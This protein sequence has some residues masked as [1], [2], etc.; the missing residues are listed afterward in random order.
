M[1]AEE[2]NPMASI[3]S[4][5]S[6]SFKQVPLAALPAMLDCILASTGISPSTLF[7]SLLNSFSKFIKCACACILSLV[8]LWG[9][10]VAA[11]AVNVKL[12][13]VKSMV[14][15]FEREMLNEIAESLFCVISTTHSWGVLEANLVPFFL[16]SVGL[17]MGMFQNEE[18]DAFEWGHCSI[19][20]GLSDLENDFD[21]DKESMLS[22]SGSFPLP[23]SCHI[24]TLIL[25]SALQ[26]F[27]IVSSTKSTLANGFCYAEKLFSNLLWDL[28]NMSERLLSQ[29]LEHRSCTIGFLLPVIFKAFGSHCSL[30]ITVR[31]KMFILSRN[32]F[33]RKIWKLCRSLFSL[34]HLERRDAYNVLSLYLSFFSST[35]GFGNA[36]ANVKAEEFD[37]RAEK[38]FWDE[39]KRGLV[40]G[41][42]PVRKQSLHILK[43]ILQISGGSQCHSGVSEKKSPEKHPIPHGMTKREMWADKEAKSLG[44]WELCNLAD[45]PLNSQQQWE[46][47]IILYEMLEEYGTHLV[48]AAWHHQLNLLLQF[49]VSNNNFTSY[50]FKGFHQKQTDILSEAFSWVTI[51]WQLGFQHDNPQVRCLIMESFLGIE[52]MKYGNTAKLVSESFVLGPFIEG[53]NDPVHHKDFG[54][55]GVYNSKTIEGAARWSVLAL[56][57]GIAFL[58][59]LASVAKHFS[60]GRAGLM[61]L[62]ECIA[63]AAHG[64]GR[65]GNEEKWTEDAFPDEVLVKSSSEN[66]S[67][68]QTSILDVLRFVIKS[69][70]QHFNPNY[71]LKVCEKV[72]E[73][74]A[75]LVSTLDVPLEILLHFIATLPRAFTDYGDDED[76]DAWESEAKRW[77]RALFLIIK[78]EHQLA[79]ILRFFQN[80]GVNICKQQN[81]LEWLPVKFLVLARSLVAEIQIMQERFTQC[82]IK[83]KCRSQIS[84]LDTEELVSFADMSSS[85]FWSSI[86]EETTLPGSVRGKLGGRSQRRLSTSNTTV[87]LQAIISMQ[88]VASISSWCAQFKS[89]V[90]LRSVWAF[91]WKFFWK[92]VSSPTCDSEVGAE[93]CLAAYEAL[94]P[95]LRALVSTSS[96]LSLDLIR[97]N[98]E[99]SAPAEEVK[100]CLDSLALS[101][102]QNINNLLAVGVLARTRRAVLLNQKWI[103]LESLLS[104]PYSTPGNVLNVEDGS[105]FFSDSTIRCIFSDL[106]ESLDNAGEGS[107]L[108]ML[109]SVRL[110]LGL[111]ALGKLDSPISSCNGVDAQ[112]C[113]LD[114]FC[115]VRLQM[116]VT[117][118]SRQRDAL[119]TLPWCYTTD[120]SSF[121]G[122]GIR[123]VKASNLKF[124]ENVIEEGTKSPRTIRLTALHLTGLWLSHPRTIKY[125]MKELKLLT[126]YGSEKYFQYDNF[127]ALVAFDEDFEAELSENQDASNEVSLL[128]KS[129]DPELTELADLANMVG[130]KKENEDCQAALESGKLFLL[131]LL[132]SAI[133]SLMGLDIL[134]LF[135]SL[136]TIC[137]VNDKDLA[138]ELYKKYSGI[139]YS[140]PEKLGIA[141]S[142]KIHRRKIRAWQMICVLSRF[143]TDD[144]A[145]QVTH[146]L[147]ISLHRNNLPAVRQYLETFAI[148]IYLKFPLLVRGQ[149]VPILRDYNMK[150]QALS[151]YVFIAAN[152]ILHASNANQSRHFNELL[153]PIIP[154]LTSHHHSLRGFTQLLVYQVFCKYFPLLDHGASEMPLEKMCFEDLK[155]YL[156]KNPDCRRLRASMEGYLD[157]YNP[158]A[159]GT[160]AGIFVNRV[161]NALHQELEF[162]CVATSL[163]EEVLNFLNDVREDLRCSMAKD[164]VTIKNESLK[165]D[166]DGNCRQTLIDSQ[167]PTE[168]SFDFQKKLTLSKHEKQDTDSSSVLGNNEAYKQLLEMEKE[169]ELLD[170]SF[171]SRSLTMKKIRASRQQFILVASLLDRIPN[172]AGLARTCE[173]FKASGLA[174]ADASILRDKQ[175]QLIS[176]T[177]EKWVP[178]IEVPVNSVKHFLEKKKRD[179][180]SI[181]GLEQTTNSVPLDHYAFP[182]KTVL[183]LGHEKE[184]IPVDIIHMLDACIEIPQLGVV[185]SLNVHALRAPAIQVTVRSGKSNS[186]LQWIEEASLAY[187]ERLR[188]SHDVFLESLLQK[189]TY[190]KLYSYTHLLNGFAVNVQSKEVLR[191]LK[192]ATGVRAIHEDV[193]M[194]KFTTH[195]PR[196]LGIPTDVWPTLGGA[197]NSG[198]GV[199]IGFIDTGINPLHPSFTGG[200]TARFTNSSKFKGKCVTGEKFPSTACNGKIVGAQYFARAAIAAGD[201][202]ATRD[203]ASPYDADG[204]GR[205][206]IPR[207]VA[208]FLHDSFC[209]LPSLR[210]LHTASTAAGNH[211]I[212][213]IAND[214]NYGYASGMAPG[215]RCRGCCGSAIINNL[216]QAVEDGVDILNLSIGPSSVPS[217]PSAFLNVLEMELLFATKAG[218]FVV[219]AAGNGGPSPSSILSFSPW[220]TSVAASIIDRKYNN[221][222]ILGN[223]R[224]FS[225]TGLARNVP[226]LA[227]APTEGEMPYRI[228]AAADVSHTNTTSVV[229][230]E[231]CQNP[232]HFILSSVR[233]KLIICTYTFD[234]EYEAASIAA[235][236]ST[237]QKIG[238]AGFIIAMDPDIGSEQIKGATMTI[239]VPAIILNSLQSS[240]ALWEY[241]NSNTIRSTSGQAV[242]FAARARILDGRQAF[243]TRQAPI[244][245]SYSS[246]GPDVSNALL[247]TADVLK[248]NIMAPGSSIWAAWSPNSEGDPSIKGQNFALVS[249]TSMATPHIAGVAALIKQKHPRW[250]PAAITSA[251]MT[252]ANTFDHSGS[253]FLAQLTNQIA[254]ATPFDFGAGSINPAQAIDPGLVFNSHFEQYV[255]FLCAVPGVDEGSVR[256]AA[257]TGCPTKKRPWCSDLNTASV[258]ISN[259]VGSRKVTRRVTN[260]SSRNEVYRVTV[261]QP[262]GVNVTVSPQVVMINGNASKHLKIVLTAIQATRTYTFGEMVLLGSRKHVVRVPIAVYKEMIMSQA[263][264][265]LVKDL[266]IFGIK[267]FQLFRQAGLVLLENLGLLG[268]ATI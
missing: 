197:E 121:T 6:D 187:K 41:E 29:S 75:L 64:V 263:A 170:Q 144:I 244:V 14:H 73:A 27:R 202:N 53:L 237:I 209:L 131:E 118:L 113:V 83:I 217:G 112:D 204:H 246:R 128:G 226:T 39:I 85:I 10:L 219:Q 235:V 165:N 45:S 46:A 150:P 28:C 185:R 148:N 214:F 224:S 106:V 208:F 147:H 127:L 181:L 243:F 58:H 129:P 107:V 137:L 228:A 196:Y 32:V 152:V 139:S 213:V 182:K 251:M 159:S 183:V 4:S 104:I 97:E 42:G 110:A 186:T 262:S 80:C 31:G 247:Q 176:V 30:E 92:T 222:I 116:L 210:F 79:P 146:N 169:D 11:V 109:R 5:L 198:E 78:G 111:I 218:V 174:I 136:E 236:A 191:T 54:V 151:S 108:P 200:S 154:L 49:S 268:V 257:G 119:A 68:C 201:F 44:V 184:G 61:G 179:G 160:P 212:P 240:R 36:N 260:V 76:L 82:G 256:R 62:A 102:L 15:A 133:F 259:L 89:D 267:I 141:L 47:F 140:K 138:K 93:I 229:E 177:A 254:P 9:K 142:R 158:I 86:I 163:M 19:Y 194:E 216:P 162:E 157:A 258:I 248:P 16:R 125:Y 37:V 207:A 266:Q 90:K 115:N 134:V 84:L 238:A 203:Y 55:K 149:L 253:P 193:K 20:H 124:V 1:N 233:N 8:G 126:L 190:N 25:E 143:V 99:F 12:Q 231:S 65:H 23:I 245:A 227:L 249:G 232:E 155:S 66:F 17:S 81:H 180:F 94:A 205:Q 153:P 70:K 114:M 71:R 52:W 220:I 265:I 130:S 50:I 51:L 21:L 88:A 171:Q 59:S 225:G 74:A 63:S 48:E 18:S 96:P 101:F 26:S 3:I 250:S 100:C 67:D 189:D 95:V 223:G 122:N 33:F 192:N 206:V 38:E 215:A 168:T 261:R 117:T 105:L 24:L 98:D 164:V 72:L 239:Q 255:Q 173:V 188:T 264:W 43:T 221:S 172:I 166:E 77:A 167:L 161:E 40:D 230:V 132:D 34:G 7:A 199:I 120:H 56:G 178:I 57:E 13:K 103:C 87:I 156:A 135:L 22:L 2:S 252:T 242:G 234:F 69:S 211:Q 195:T 241:Y 91:L 175:F 60:F 123:H 145:A 35:K